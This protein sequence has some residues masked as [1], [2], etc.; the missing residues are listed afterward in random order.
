MRT[1]FLGIFLNED[2]FS[3]RFL[4]EN[5]FSGQIVKWEPIFYAL[6]FSRLRIYFVRIL[7]SQVASVDY[8]KIYFAGTL[9]SQITAA[10]DCFVFFFC[11]Q[12]P[13]RHS[14]KW[15]SCMPKC[16]CADISII[17]CNYQRCR[18][19]IGRNVILF[20]DA[21]RWKQFYKFFEYSLAFICSKQFIVCQQYVRILCSLEGPNCID[22]YS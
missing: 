5:Q 4:I 16:A 18:I 1:N 7:W 20:R 8:A 13:P 3:G 9:W 6:C 12:F 14:E 2:K 17:Y 22:P 21:P 19:L 11:F 10:A 15:R